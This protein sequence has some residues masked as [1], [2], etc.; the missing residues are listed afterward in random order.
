MLVCRK[1][2]ELFRCNHRYKNHWFYVH[3]SSSSSRNM[4]VVGLQW[5]TWECACDSVKT[6]DDTWFPPKRK[7]WYNK[8]TRKMCIYIL[9]GEKQRNTVCIQCAVSLST[10]A[11]HCAWVGR[12]FAELSLVQIRWNS[13]LKTHEKVQTCSTPSFRSALYVAFD[14]SSKVCPIKQWSYAHWVNWY[15]DLRCI[16]TIHYYYYYVLHRR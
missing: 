12:A 9:L 5:S 10:A 13:H 7:K 1:K 16:R 15:W 3:Q 6:F 2:G 11:G 8:V 4:A 14:N